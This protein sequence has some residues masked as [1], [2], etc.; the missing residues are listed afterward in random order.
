MSKYTVCETKIEVKNK[1]VLREAIKRLLKMKFGIH[2]ISDK[3]IE[4]HDEAVN[5]IGYAGDIRPEKANVIIRG[6]G[7][8]KLSFEQKSKLKV[9]GQNALPPAYNDLGFIESNG[10]Y[11][12]IIQ[13]FEKDRLHD[14]KAALHSM[15][16]A[17]QVAKHFEAHKEKNPDVSLQIIDTGEII[18]DKDVFIQRLFEATQKGERLKVKFS[19]P[20]QQQT[21]RS[22]V[23]QTEFVPQFGAPIV[24]R[25]K[26]TLIPK[27]KEKEKEKRKFK[28][29]WR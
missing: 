15:I 5:L 20:K 25:P 13:D 22:Q 2:N 9:S 23:K 11:Q 6:C 1:D 7:V 14:F 19:V 17:L 12:M 8:E 4:F 26:P 3:D 21:G 16:N 10:F 24:Q 27:E 29:Y 18:T 28:R